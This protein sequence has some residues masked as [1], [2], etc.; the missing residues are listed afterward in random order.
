MNISSSH[1]QFLALVLH[2]PQLTPRSP[3]FNVHSWIA[4]VN[5]LDFSPLM[6][7]KRP[8]H[9]AGVDSRWHHYTTSEKTNSM[10]LSM[11]KRPNYKQSPDQTHFSP[12]AIS[13]G[14]Y[15]DKAAGRRACTGKK[16]TRD[17]SVLS[18]WCLGDVFV[19]SRSC[20]GLVLVLSLSCLGDVSVLFWWCLCDVSVMSRSCLGLFLVMSRCCSGV[21]LLVF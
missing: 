15:M 7:M 11:T 21:V 2:D 6:Q 10:F 18:R 12:I 13:L 3:V 20:L 4:S 5:R 8:L 14:S 16:F 1:P 9:F 17:V 19:M